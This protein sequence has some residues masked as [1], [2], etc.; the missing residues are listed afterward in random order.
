MTMHFWL[1]RALFV[2]AL[3]LF[4]LSGT[5]RAD[6]FL[7][8]PAAPRH[9]KPA[10]LLDAFNAV[11]A[12]ALAT[13]IKGEGEGEAEAQPQASTI[14]AKALFQKGVEIKIP[15]DA[16]VYITPQYVPKNDR[17]LKAYSVDMA[18]KGK[19]T[20]APGLLGIA[21]QTYS[22][23]GGARAAK[24]N[25][26]AGWHNL[27]H[28]PFRLVP[29]APARPPA[30][31]QPPSMHQGPTWRDFPARATIRLLTGITTRETQEMAEMRRDDD[32]LTP[33]ENKSA[34]LQPQGL[35]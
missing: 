10:T 21:A 29:P 27:R 11:V 3:V 22:T 16:K 18:A 19:G 15:R 8:H 9:V 31:A 28:L 32:G 20:A 24:N 14:D 17:Y 7:T 35:K 30:P 6:H 4:G 12:G 2:L 26:W 34:M 5:A 23:Q 25:V 33:Q 13:T 1:G